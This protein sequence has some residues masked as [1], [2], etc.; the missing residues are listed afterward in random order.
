MAMQPRFQTWQFLEFCLTLS[1]FENAITSRILG[2]RLCMLI[3]LWL[4]LLGPQWTTPCPSSSP[5]ETV[6]VILIS[7][8]I[9]ISG[10]LRLFLSR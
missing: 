10:I 5:D 7:L 3:R 6:A 2:V 9:Q 4:K 8:C 1:Q